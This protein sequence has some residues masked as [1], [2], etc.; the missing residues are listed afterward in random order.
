MPP[1][2]RKPPCHNCPPAKERQPKLPS[3]PAKAPAEVRDFGTS[4]ALRLWNHILFGTGTCVGMIEGYTALNMP[5][6]PL[7][8]IKHLR[9]RLTTIINTHEE[10]NNAA[11]HPQE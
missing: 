2:N 1:R 7:D 3:Q 11:A 10:R 8:G 4:E 5:G 9:D 6:D